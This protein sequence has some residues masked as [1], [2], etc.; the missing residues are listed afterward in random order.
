MKQLIFGITGTT[1]SGKTTVSKIFQSLGVKVIDADKVYHSLIKKGQKCLLEICEYFG[2]VLTS[3][4]ELDRKK[5]SK[6]VFADSK[7][8][9]MLN[10]IT[11]KYIK[12][13]IIRL[14]DKNPVCAIDAAVLIGSEIAPLCKFIVTVTAPQDIRKKRIME[15][16]CLSEQE[17]MDRISSQKSDDFYKENSDFVIIND[18]N[19]DIENEVK[20]ILAAMSPKG[21]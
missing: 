10:K 20:T 17:A 6:I 5:L 8:L 13:E 9:E 12:E 15:R 3:H 18:G 11:H 1:G 19:C 21:E 4:G 7:K 14:I 16:D 2:D